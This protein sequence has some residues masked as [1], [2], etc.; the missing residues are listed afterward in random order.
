MENFIQNYWYFFASWA[1]SF[2]SCWALIK[3]SKQLQL[4]DVSVKRSS[5][6]G[7]IPK[8]GGVG[9]VFV[10]I[11]YVFFFFTHF[12]LLVICLLAFFSLLGD[13]KEIASWIRFSV[14]TICAAALLFFA[15]PFFFESIIWYAGFLIFLVATMNFYNFMD[16]IDGI[17][18]FNGAASFFLLGLYAYTYEKTDWV[19]FC[20][21]LFFAL[22][23][24]LVW[25]FSFFGKKI[26]MGD[27]GSVFLGAIIAIIILVLA[28][29]W[30]DFF[31]LCFALFAFYAD[32]ILTLFTKKLRKIKLS[33][34][35]RLH[36]YQIFAN[37]KA[38]RHWKVSI[39]YSIFQ[40]LSFFAVFVF[41]DN[42]AELA[43]FYVVIMAAVFLLYLFSR[44]RIIGK[45]F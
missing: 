44:K 7:F 25:N 3:Y 14:Q 8:G 31:R 38:I 41:A 11:F 24:F 39:G 42:W 5:H 13:R 23:G 2:L 37:E 33:S 4:I 27:V 1:V 20:F 6:K 16:G 30:F 22:L 10:T 12:W 9:L 21:L 26:F 32:C 40:V 28:Q 17:A 15:S 45:F 34:P 43:A 18:G 29:D 36:L 19:V 35:H